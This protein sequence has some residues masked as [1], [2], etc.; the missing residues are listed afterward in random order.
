VILI[1]QYRHAV[2]RWLW[3]IPA[4]LRH[5]QEPPRKAAARELR[6]ETGYGARYWRLLGSFLS[7][8]GFCEESIRIYLAQALGRRRT[9]ALDE[10]EFVVPRVFARKDVFKMIRQGKIEDA[11]TVLGLQ[12]AAR[13]L[14]WR[15]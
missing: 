10:D 5:L 2:K 8:P 12:L 11:K 7:S 4:G 15:S 6:E 14:G 3:E 13:F 9:L 1:R